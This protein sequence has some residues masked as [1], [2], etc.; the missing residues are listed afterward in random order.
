MTLS[1][2]HLLR[3][4]ALV[5]VAVAL[6]LGA[7]QLTF[8]QVVATLAAD[9]QLIASGL[10]GALKQLST[11]GLG[12]FTPAAQ[13]AASNALTGIQQVAAS[14][15]QASG[16]AAAQPLV[17]QLQTY[18]AA[19][20]VALPVNLLPQPAG[21]IISAA[22]ILLPTLF[23]AVNLAAPPPVAAPVVTLTTDQARTV[24]AA[25]AS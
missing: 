16:Q 5:P 25:P 15:G 10:A 19:F 22:I 20:L 13:A 24:L 8:S 12:W 23:T 4:S 11:L 3:S 6:P 7:C 21:L 2:R 1:R 14:L 9:A 18:L 17:Q